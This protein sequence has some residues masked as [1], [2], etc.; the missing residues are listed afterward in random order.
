MRA[1]DQQERAALER[2]RAEL[3]GRAFTYD[4]AGALVPVAELDTRKLPKAVLTP[5]FVAD[6]PPPPAG[7][8]KGRKKSGA[9]PGACL[10]CFSRFGTGRVHLL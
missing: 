10:T 8:G 1:K 7:E 4:H 3:K 5:K 9:L 2:M 6:A